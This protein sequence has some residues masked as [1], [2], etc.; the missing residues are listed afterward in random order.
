M[1]IIWDKLISCK[2]EIIDIFDEH[3]GEIEEPGMSQFNQP[4]NGCP[5]MATEVIDEI[6]KIAPNIYFVADS[7]ALIGKKT[8]ATLN[9][10]IEILKANQEGVLNIE[11]YAS[12]EGS[13]EYNEDLSLR[14]A[15]S[16]RNYLIQQGIS[17]E[18]IITSGLGENE[19]SGNNE[20]AEGRTENRR[21]Q[22]KA[23]L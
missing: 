15:A 8:F 6:N 18:R 4:D 5:E 19:P 11:G 17:E 13:E 22:F 7:D 1:S 21:V 23:K 16:V 12:S 9:E 10:I 3:C 2:D 20:T 14:R